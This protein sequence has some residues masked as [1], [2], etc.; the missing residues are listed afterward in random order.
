[1]EQRVPRNEAIKHLRLSPLGSSSTQTFLHPL[2]NRLTSRRGYLRPHKQSIKSSL[3]FFF[4]FYAHLARN[5]SYTARRDKTAN[6]K[7]TRPFPL[8][9][10]GITVYDDASSSL[11]PWRVKPGGNASDGE[12]RKINRGIRA[13]A[14]SFSS[15]KRRARWIENEIRRI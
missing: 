13:Q 15:L 6:D 12:Q 11:F 9:P 7:I 14:G 1:M 4:F 10:R 8:L 3:S 2:R 5:I